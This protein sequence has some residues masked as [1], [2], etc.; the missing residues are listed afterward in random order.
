MSY[1]TWKLESVK[2]SPGW[3]KTISLFIKLAF[4]L[5]RHP[6]YLVAGKISRIAKRHELS[7]IVILDV[8]T[9]EGRPW[10]LANL[11]IDKSLN[12]RI[13]GLDAMQPEDHAAKKRK[14]TEFTSKKGQFQQLLREEQN[15]SF[16][17]VFMLDVIK[18]MGKE[19]GYLVPYEMNR[20]SKFGIGITTPNGFFWTATDGFP[21]L[22]S[23]RERLVT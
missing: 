3:G 12:L 7:T 13:K 16:D 9:G 20:I 11:F 18:H 21:P 5:A 15:N 17:L 14:N 2:Q 19:D 4:R 10:K 8:G 6:G 1:E 22:L 23:T